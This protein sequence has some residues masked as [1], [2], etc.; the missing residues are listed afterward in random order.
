VEL[1]RIRRI[2]IEHEEALRRAWDDHFRA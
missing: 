1:R 2:L